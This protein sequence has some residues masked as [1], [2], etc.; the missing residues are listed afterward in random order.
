MFTDTISLSP[1]IDVSI[2]LDNEQ[3]NG[4]RNKVVH[5]LLKRVDDTNPFVKVTPN[6]NIIAEEVTKLEKSLQKENFDIPVDFISKT[7]IFRIESITEANTN[8]LQ[9]IQQKR[10]LQQQ[11]EPDPVH[12][13]AR[14]M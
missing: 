7:A 6:T 12:K 9:P 5:V 14:L 11:K 2:D 10:C 1:S 3:L 13:K 4:W 8:A